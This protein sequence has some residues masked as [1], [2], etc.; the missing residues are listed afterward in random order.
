MIS[1]Q[2]CVLFNVQKHMDLFLTR[3]RKDNKLILCATEALV[4][5]ET[6]FSAPESCKVY[7]G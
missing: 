5:M 4:D 2:I 7:S 3:W 1:T 6:G